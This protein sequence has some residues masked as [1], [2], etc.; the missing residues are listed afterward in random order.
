MNWKEQVFRYCER[1]QDG[2][3]WAEPLNAITNAAFL[4]AALA[5]AIEV[6]KRDPRERGI[7]AS[8]LIVL[9]G[10]IGGGSFL[11]HTFAT[12]WAGLADTIPIVVFM[13]AYLAYALRVYLGLGWIS[14]SLG[15]LGFFAAFQYAGTIQCRPGLISVMA[16]ARGPCLNGTVGYVPGFL[17][18]LGIGAALAFRRHPA[19]R[20]LLGA[21]GVFLVSMALRTVDLEICPLTQIAGRA[22]GTHFLWHLLNATTLYL[23]LM[24]AVRHGRSVRVGPPIASPAV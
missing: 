19:A 3:F 20:Y 4:L 24:A 16:A 1:G 13:L 8:P 6:R 17:A 5:A 7:A 18:M 21:G 10:V 2:G 12:R 15:L 11:F 14:I 22:L 23:L 9:V